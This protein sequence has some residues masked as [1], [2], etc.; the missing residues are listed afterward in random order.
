MLRRIVLAWLAALLMLWGVW[1]PISLLSFRPG[2]ILAAQYVPTAF[3]HGASGGYIVS[4]VQSAAGTAGFGGTTVTKA[5]SSNMASGDN[6]LACA[7]WYA[8][9]TGITATF[10][11]SQGKTY[12]T[13]SGTLERADSTT[14]YT[15]IGVECGHSTQTSAA[16]ANTVTC[17]F[18][19]SVG[20]N[21]CS[22]IEVSHSG[23]AVQIDQ[24]KV[25]TG[26]TANPSAGSITPSITGTMGFA[27]IMQDDGSGSGTAFTA[28]TGW[29][30][31]Q[32]TGGGA[33]DEGAEYQA[34]SGTS[35]VSGNFTGA[36]AHAWAAAVANYKAQ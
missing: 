3:N 29:T 25:A 26:S 9:S 16:A 27:V 8:G 10:S 13:D 17:H 21:W 19:S 23:G 1:P 32:N 35:S 20:N 12:T 2:P 7:Q 5:F 31:F 22:I 24:A 30:L 18:S 14:D 15:E 34:I 4:Y 28:G 36:A 11:D 6:V 33:A